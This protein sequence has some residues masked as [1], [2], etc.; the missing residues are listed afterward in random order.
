MLKGRGIVVPCRDAEALADTL[1]EIARN[2][3]GYEAMRQR[4]AEWASQFSLNGLREALAD[5]LTRWWGFEIA[6]SPDVMAP[7]GSVARRKENRANDSLPETDCRTNFAHRRN[8]RS[9]FARD[10]RRRT[11][12]RQ[13][14]QRA[15]P[16]PV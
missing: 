2:P 11:G 1:C 15:P 14:G 4:S 5:L 8:A 9:R 10:R 7:A 13:P 6:A 16:R 3:G 12:R